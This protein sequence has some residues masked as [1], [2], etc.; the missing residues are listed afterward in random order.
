MVE[1]S[2]N[3]KH[4][5]P[6]IYIKKELEQKVECLPRVDLGHVN[7]LTSLKELLIS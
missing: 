5:F 2:N 6:P 1:S 7:F 3:I 4:F